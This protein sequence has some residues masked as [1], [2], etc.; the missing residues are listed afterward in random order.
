MGS[1]SRLPPG[2]SQVPV[3]AVPARVEN[4][5]G[6][7]PALI[8]AGGIDLFVGEDIAYAQCLIGSCVATQLEVV[9]G[10][11]NAFDTVPSTKVGARFEQ[12]LLNA[13]GRAFGLPA[14]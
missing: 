11:F 13:F 5:H 1:P 3:A 10:A 12:T 8:G 4:L 7:P 9:P 6:L 2:S 14:T